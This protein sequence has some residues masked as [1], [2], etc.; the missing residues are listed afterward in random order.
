MNKNEAIEKTKKYLENFGL[1]ENKLS[2][3]NCKFYGD[4]LYI[5]YVRDN[6]NDIFYLVD[7]IMDNSK[8]VVHFDFQNSVGIH[9]SS[10]SG[11]VFADVNILKVLIKKYNEW[12]HREFVEG[13]EM[14]DNEE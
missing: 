4:V 10:D 8:M 2:K 7:T 9:Y 12:L 11:V 1:I 13:L 5:P 3:E 14:E 6:Y